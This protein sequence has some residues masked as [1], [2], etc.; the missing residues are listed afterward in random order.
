[1]RQ[2][3]TPGSPGVR[4]SVGTMLDVTS[5]SAP[6][7]RTEPART[8]LDRPVL[9]SNIV[10]GALW[11]FLLAV[12]W[13]DQFG[14]WALFGMG[15]VYVAAGSVFLAAVYARE[16][17]T[18]GQE[19]LAWAIPWLVAV[20]LWTLLLAAFDLGNSVSGWLL[21]LFAGLCI[22]TPCYLAWQIVAL[23]VRQL[24]DWLSGTAP[25]R[26]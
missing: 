14:S 23:A 10:S 5:T 20:A 26:P 21:T 19:A 13:S 22:G 12:P 4:C 24:V 17:L 6:A 8:R 2:Q 3:R 7:S 9:L 18:M 25:S 15:A 11:L 16:V 1:M